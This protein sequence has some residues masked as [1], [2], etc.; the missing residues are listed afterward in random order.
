MNRSYLSAITVAVAA[1]V[2]GQALAADTS[3]SK[4]REE[5]K[6]ELA[7]AIR[8]GNFVANG[9]TGQ[10]A[11]ELSPSRY[12]AKPAVQGKTREAVRAELA[13]AIRSGNYLVS[14]E[15]GQKANERSS[16]LYSATSN[17]HGKTRE[18]VKAELAE[19]IR[20]G[21]MPA[22]DASGLLLSQKFPKRYGHNI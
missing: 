3:E 6:A 11:N 9:E 13:E 4:T 2:A 16:S 12:P 22:D 1:L 18:A 17:V 7:E 10:K 20:S 8:S 5:V 14:G 21:N 19:S 15:T